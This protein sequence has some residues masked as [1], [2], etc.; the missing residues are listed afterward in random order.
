MDH[1]EAARLFPAV[2]APPLIFF[3]K[4]DLDWL[5]DGFFQRVL[6][7]V[8]KTIGAFHCVLQQPH[9][10]GLRFFPA[11]SVQPAALR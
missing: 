9:D 2:F 4:T 8:A 5:D 3:S 7:Y 6:G 10:R 11:L 1:E